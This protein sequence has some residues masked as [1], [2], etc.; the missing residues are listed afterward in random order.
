[1]TNALRHSVGVCCIFGNKP[2]DFTRD[3]PLFE[4]GR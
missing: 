2:A 3:A 1:L 4:N